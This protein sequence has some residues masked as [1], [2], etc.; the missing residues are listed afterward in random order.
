MPTPG[1][2]ETEVPECCGEPKRWRKDSRRTS[3]GNWRCL[4]E[5][6]KIDRRYF[7]N[8]TEAERERRRAYQR[9]A[10]RQR[11]EALSGLDY[12]RLLLTHRR[13]KALSR[14]R[15]RQEARVG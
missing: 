9:E 13:H 2:L 4:V 14:R 10:K 11:Y 5:K 6:R 15:E 1:S 3:G 7:E 8:M 12:N